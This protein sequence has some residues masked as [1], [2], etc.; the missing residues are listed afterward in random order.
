M[1]GL[2][3]NLGDCAC[4]RDLHLCAFSCKGHQ[5]PPIMFHG[6]YGIACACCGSSQ[7]LQPMF[8]EYLFH[9]D[10]NR[11]SNYHQSLLAHV[12]G[13]AAVCKLLQGYL[14]ET[15][16]QNRVGI[17]TRKN[18]LLKLLASPMAPAST[19]GEPQGCPAV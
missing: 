12:K 5:Q 2:I 9:Q 8:L 18:F 3:C 15:N 19:K 4:Q 14:L 17:D 16:L 7:K 10:Q 13:I 6:P 1:R 11:W